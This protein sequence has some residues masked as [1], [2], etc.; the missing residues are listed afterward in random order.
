MEYTQTVKYWAHQKIQAENW[1]RNVTRSMRAAKFH[2]AQSGKLKDL[3]KVQKLWGCYG[4]VLR[5]CELWIARCN[6]EISLLKKPARL[7]SS[8]EAQNVRAI[9]QA[10]KLSDE[11]CDGA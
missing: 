10:A 3:Q 5:T 6:A 1:V 7:L 4:E 9:V 2:Y 8:K 11:E